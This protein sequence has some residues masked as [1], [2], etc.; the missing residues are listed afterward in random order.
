MSSR[1]PVD[2]QFMECEDCL[3]KP[4]PPV[5]CV[6]CR[7]NRSVI[8]ELHKMIESP[9]E[10]FYE[11]IEVPVDHK[12]HPFSEE[13]TQIP[14]I[15]QIA[16]LWFWNGGTFEVERWGNVEIWHPEGGGNINV[17]R[18]GFS[19]SEAML[20]GRYDS[21]LNGMAFCG[22]PLGYVDQRIHDFLLEWTDT[23][24]GPEN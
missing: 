24:S 11:W 14:R 23:S 1:W 20:L 18:S 6:A 19:L 3:S 4:G 17:N 10:R 13:I 8:A 22:I 2:L 7:K 16:W 12:A 9:L 21:Y 5:L 15:E